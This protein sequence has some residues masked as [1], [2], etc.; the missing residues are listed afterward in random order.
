MTCLHIQESKARFCNTTSKVR[1]SHY[2][3]LCMLAVENAGFFCGALHESYLEQCRL[4]GGPLGF[5]QLSP[6]RVNTRIALHPLMCKLVIHT[7]KK[8]LYLRASRSEYTVEWWASDQ[9]DAGTMLQLDARGSRKIS[10][11][12]TGRSGGWQEDVRHPRIKCQPVL[13]S[14]G[15]K[16]IEITTPNFACFESWPL[17]M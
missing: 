16:K 13:S 17:K 8:R 1:K 2:A 14:T 7:T 9:C 5:L 3:K 6:V 11:N 12:D 15:D 4:E 10:S